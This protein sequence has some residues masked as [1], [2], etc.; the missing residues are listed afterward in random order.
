MLLKN[1]SHITLLP[2]ITVAAFA[3]TWISSY[4]DFSV[5]DLLFIFGFCAI[6]LVL[7]SLVLLLAARAASGI[8][9]ALFALFALFNAYSLH[10][11]FI[12][13]ITG[14]EG[15][16]Q[17]VLAVVGLYIFFSLKEI[18]DKSKIGL[19]AVGSSA[20]LLVVINF[21]M[22]LWADVGVQKD[23]LIADQKVSFATDR[24]DNP[25]I[26]RN[27]KSV[28]FEARPNVY[29][30]EFDSLMPEALLNRHLSLEHVPYAVY[31]KEHFQSFRNMF[32]EV[33]PTRGSLNSLLAFDLDYFKAL[34]VKLRSELFSGNVKSPLTEIFRN[35]GYTI[36]TLNASNYIGLS[37]GPYVDNYFVGIPF[38]VC[39]FIDKKVRSFAFFGFCAAQGTYFW[40]MQIFY[41]G[42]LKHL[43]ASFEQQSKENKP[44]F[45]LA[46]LFSPGHTSLGFKSGNQDDMEEY[47]RAYMKNSIETVDMIEQLKS[48]VD[49]SGGKD[50]LII[51][52]DHGPYLSRTLKYSDDPGFYIRD[53]Y[54]I[55]GG[56]YP[57]NQCNSYFEEMNV[58]GYG[59]PIIVLESLVRCLSGGESP[60]ITPQNITAPLGASINTTYERLK[61]E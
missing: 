21:S 15:Y 38:T 46:Y 22:L 37:K 32:A 58:L 3:L 12:N 53:R 26:T 18:A 52:G 28:K 49:R 42:P 13:A 17:L 45:F 20:I 47:R 24:K 16:I 40:Q 50:I 4:Q 8:A 7:Q 43:L 51:M 56:A 23:G 1:L 2:V 61:Y 36:N 6:A 30:V 54:G 48:F 60:F 34:P 39:E 59:T 33:V 31:L 35:N 14:L 19:L 11:L 55:Y 10:L 41:S 29:I 25:S 5:Y 57:R 44:Q 9:N 27:V